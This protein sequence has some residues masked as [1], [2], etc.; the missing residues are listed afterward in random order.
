M[1]H[2]HLGLRRRDGSM[3]HQLFRGWNRY[4]DH[5]DEECRSLRVIRFKAVRHKTLQTLKFP[6]FRLSSHHDKECTFL[7]PSAFANFVPQSAHHGLCPRNPPGDS[8]LSDLL[9]VSSTNFITLPAPL[10]FA[11]FMLYV[12]K[13]YVS[14]SISKRR[15]NRKNAIT[16]PEGV[17]RRQK[18]CAA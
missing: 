15:Q 7:K 4:T 1:P 10:C 13:N 6:I 16:V 14:N 18:N 11:L 9:T 8:H 3:R 5:G 17:H 2:E 12:P